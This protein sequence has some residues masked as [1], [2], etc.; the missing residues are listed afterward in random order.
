MSS[1]LLFTVSALVLWSSNLLPAQTFSANLTGVVTDSSGAAVPGAEA[2]L[3]DPAT[4]DI[5]KTVANEQGRYTFSQILPATYSLTITHS[6]FRQYV[7]DGLVLSPNQSAEVNVQLQVGSVSE[8]VEITGAAPILDT[9]TSNESET[10]STTMMESLPIA[11]RA[12][13]VLVL[14]AGAGGSYSS[15]SAFGPGANDDQ[16]VARF[17]IFGGRQNSSAI[18]I[19]GI[20]SLVGDWGGLLAE[21]GTD[22]VQDL[23][24]LRNTYEAQYGRSSAGVINMTTKGGTDIYHGTLLE[25]FRNDK[26]NANTFFSNLTGT[27]RVKSTRNEYGGNLSGPIWKQKRLY[28]FFGYDEAGYGQPGTLTAT[29]PTLLQRQGN[30]SQT[31]NAN[32]TLQTIYDPT[33]TIQTST[34]GVYTRTPFPG[35]IVPQSQFDAIAKNYLTYVPLPNTAGNPITQANNYFNAG[36]SHY[37]SWHADSRG[38]FQ[39]TDK[40]FIWAKVTKARSDDEY[41][42]NFWPLPVATYEPQHHPRIAVSSGATYIFSPTTVVNVTVG[43]GRWFEQW[44]NPSLGFNM[45]SLGFSQALASQF[46]V[47]TS[48]AVTITN[49]SSFGS[50]RNLLL[51]RNNYNTQ[52][53]VTKNTGPHSIKFGFD[54]EDQQLNRSDEFSAFFGF[55]QQPT[56][57]PNPTTNNGLTGNGFASLLLGAGTSNGNCGSF[58][59]NCG[60]LLQNSP[61]L[62]NAY[63]AWYVQDAWKVTS[64][65]IVNYGLRYEIQPGMTER[66]NDMASWD[67]H[68]VNPIG[69]Q[70]GLP[71]LLGA[72]EFTNS[73]NR[74]PYNTPYNN[75]APRL[76]L[77]YR[78]TDKLVVRSGYGI[79]YTRSVPIY[80]NSP[81]NDGYAVTTPW[82]TSLNNGITVQNYWANAFPQGLTPITGSTNGLLQQVGLAVNEFARNRPT[83]YIQE[84]SLDVQ[85]QLGRDTAM[86]MGYNGSQ[87]RKLIENGAFNANELPDK[88]LSL[89]NALLASVPNPFYGTAIASGTLSG[90]TVQYGQLLLP[91]P[92]YTAVNLLLT[93]GASS[94]FNALSAKVTHRFSQGLTLVASYQ[95]SKAIDNVS[96]DGSGTIRDYNNLSLERSVSAHDVPQNLVVTYRYEFPFGKGRAFGKS[97]SRGIDLALGGWSVAGIWSYHSGL[98]LAFTTTNNTNSF[99]GSQLPNITNGAQLALPNPSRFE[100]FNTADV[101]QP[102]AFTFG[103]APRE[104][105]YVRA[106]PME[107][108]DMGLTKTFP[109]HW[110]NVKLS[111]RADAFNAFNH[112]QFSAPNTNAASTTFGQVTTSYST[113]RN[114]Q[115]ALRLTF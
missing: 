91:Y 80:L 39:P 45:A 47:D 77:A 55:T 13:L 49:Y 10:L 22:T 98:P 60:A 3:K 34:P 33:T 40:L 106:A 110:E 108:M 68:L 43:G 42:P 112:N 94:S 59:P 115:L 97:W 5:H 9:Q 76:G 17:N 8:S 6:G 44:P 30:F 93:P 89:G 83:P 18:M 114:I 57:G 52:L 72:I 37:H 46:A 74:A 81:S 66:Y 84:Y 19:D 99:G 62:S 107:N 85:Y 28:G 79:T 31:Y 29:L 25:Y 86:E 41:G 1:R 20:P 75:L 87:G 105:G 14:A 38:D 54:Y 50:S 36:V 27:P 73:S 103:N 26:L 7:L 70:A 95:W 104:I 82:V 24:V 92:Q 61:A 63:F 69:A 4:N 32:G 111:F 78:V 48:P 71:N 16:N 21:P 109:L 51:R 64:R 56:S 100:W 67:P 90:P 102:P 11:N 101:T 15:T 88:D 58:V 65:L 23:Q 12:P 113:P 2:V 96:E 35:N 53:N